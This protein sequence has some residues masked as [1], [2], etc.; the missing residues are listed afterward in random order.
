MAEKEYTR[1]NINY[2]LK[3]DFLLYNKINIINGDTTKTLM[4]KNMPIFP[5]P[6]PV[7]LGAIVL[8]FW[9]LC[10][11]INIVLYFDKIK[12]KINSY[13]KIRSK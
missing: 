12:E 10:L 8:L 7:Y 5:L 1:N 6:T 2:K 11:Y 3:R 13:K 9:S 4:L